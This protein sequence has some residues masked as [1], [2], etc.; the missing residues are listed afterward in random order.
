MPSM[1]YTAA[2][3]REGPY[4]LATVTNLDGV[5]TWADSFSHLD[6][7]VRE[8][9]AVADDL[10]DGAENSIHVEWMITSNREGH[11]EQS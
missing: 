5:S 2:L 3:T 1:T 7:Y 4:W 9:I 6:T 10:P 11:E 8:A